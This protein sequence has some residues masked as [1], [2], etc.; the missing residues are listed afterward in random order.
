M[1]PEAVLFGRV[2]LVGAAVNLV[3]AI[4]GILI[5]DAML[6][7]LGQ[8]PCS[9]PIW[10]RFAGMLIVLVTL[11][12]IP[13]ALNPLRY[14]VIAWLVVVNRAAGVVFFLIFYREYLLFGF[15]DLAFGVLS[16]PLLCLLERR[17]AKRNGDGVEVGWL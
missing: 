17:I 6:A 16:L 12:D 4:P 3:L 13:A 10:G 7:M 5:P 9:D 14:R 15:L 8:R 1:N 2:L 11:P